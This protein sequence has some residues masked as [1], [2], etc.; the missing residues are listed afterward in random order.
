M[1]IVY[2]VAALAMWLAVLGLALDCKCV[3]SGPS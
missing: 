1:G 3:L 2:R